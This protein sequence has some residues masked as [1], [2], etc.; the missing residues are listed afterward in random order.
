MT[1]S[2]LVA[3][4]LAMAVQPYLL[5]PTVALG[6]CGRDWTSPSSYLPRSSPTESTRWSV[7]GV[8]AKVCYGSPGARGREVFGKLVAWGELWRTGA[9]EPT[10]IFTNGPLRVAGIDIGP[11]RYSVYTIPGPDAW[12]VFVTASTFH[13]GNAISAAVRDR[14]I[15]SATL[16]P[17]LVE[18]D[19]VESL[20]LNW[21]ATTDDEGALVLEWETTRLEIPIEA[22]R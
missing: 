6:P 2:V 18:G 8:D 16:T 19:P 13:W 14:E 7:A 1:L 9:N 17:G 4:A 3:L 5:P 12:Q 10:R 20:T 11:G 22:G 15:G 21:Q